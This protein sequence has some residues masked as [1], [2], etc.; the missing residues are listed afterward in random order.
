M[1]LVVYGEQVAKFTHFALPSD[2]LYHIPTSFTL[3]SETYSH[4]TRSAFLYIIINVFQNLQAPLQFETIDFCWLRDGDTIQWPACVTSMNG[5]IGN[6]VSVAANVIYEYDTD[7]INHYY[8][9]EE[10]A[11]K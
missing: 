10:A 11:V 4:D 2:C 9:S 8:E 5:N 1:Q 7:N 6:Y 3:I